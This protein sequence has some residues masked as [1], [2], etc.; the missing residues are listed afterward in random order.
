MDSDES[1][2][3]RERIVNDDFLVPNEYFCPICHCLL[4]KPVSCSSCQN[5]FCCKCIQKCLE[6]NPTTCPF[7]CTPFEINR[8]PPHIQSIVGRLRIRCRNTSFGCTQI[9]SYDSLEQHEHVA[10]IFRTKRCTTCEELVL[11]N[12]IDEHQLLCQPTVLKCN[13]CECAVERTLFES[14]SQACL[15]QMLSRLLPQLRDTENGVNNTTATGEITTGRNLLLAWYQ[16]SME[17]IANPPTISLP[18]LQR[19]FESRQGSLLYRLS[20]M[21]LLLLR[22][23][24]TVPHILIMLFYIG[25]VS[26]VTFLIISISATILQ[27]MKASVYLACAQ[28][29]L[30]SGLLTF[31][32]PVLFQTFHDT[33]IIIF[34]SLVCIF[35]Q[36]AY[37][38]FKL[39]LLEMSETPTVLSLY[40]IG[41]FVLMKLLLLLIRLYIYCIPP[42]LTATCL[43]WTT[44]FLAFCLR[45][46]L[47]PVPPV[48]PVTNDEND[49]FF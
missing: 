45:R 31:G 4:W 6:I 23:P 41:F 22:N 3:D 47:N 33:T 21:F 40:Y 2:I 36:S 19:V 18:G 39:D 32:L 1:Y 5:L 8:A 46:I 12:Q 11:V 34:V 7:R 27:R 37:P 13:W 9:L 28:T 29:L 30:F 35:Y 42:Y 16:R 15:E 14:H 43:A 49:I 38:F 17:E 44:F 26:V 24:K 48:I 10:C 25:F 20:S